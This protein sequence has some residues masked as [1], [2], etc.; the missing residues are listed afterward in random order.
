M[1]RDTCFR[2]SELSDPA[3]V[4]AE[5]DGLHGPSARI[6]SEVLSEFGHHRN[7][8]AHPRSVIGRRKRGHRVRGRHAG[9]QQRDCG[10]QG[11][12]FFSLFSPHIYLYF[13]GREVCIAL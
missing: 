4:R 10:A 12:T 2:R 9:V 11:K 1:R 6:R 13:G 3:E 7:G 5:L 8:R